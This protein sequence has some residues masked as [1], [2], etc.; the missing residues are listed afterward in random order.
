MSCEV[1][2]LNGSTRRAGIVCDL[3]CVDP[4][5]P[6]WSLTHNKSSV[7]EMKC[8]KVQVCPL[9]HLLNARGLLLAASTPTQVHPLCL[10]AI[11]GGCQAGTH[12]IHL[13]LV[14]DIFYMKRLW[15][16]LTCRTGMC[17]HQPPGEG[18]GVW[19]PV[20]LGLLMSALRLARLR[21]KG[22][23]AVFWTYYLI[24]V[25]TIMTPVLQWR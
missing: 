19:I 21:G 14:G 2:G 8:L 22:S 7:N 9:N 11:G 1:L 15:G 3:F 16:W 13:F 18:G 5:G 12:P 4:Q 23:D 20:F 24:G 17:P 6:V 10:D 25:G